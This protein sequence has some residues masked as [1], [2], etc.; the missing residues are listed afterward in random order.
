MH[1][2]QCFCERVPSHL[3]R[4]TSQVTARS[5][6]TLQPA[7]LAVDC[8]WILGQG[9]GVP[10]WGGLALA[11]PGPRCPHGP[12]GRPRPGS[13]AGT[14]LGGAARLPAPPLPVTGG[15]GAAGRLPPRG[16]GYPSRGVRWGG[17]L[18]WAQGE[19]L[20]GHGGVWGFPAA[21]SYTAVKRRIRHYYMGFRRLPNRRE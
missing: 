13:A 17:C 1:Y 16:V 8:H 10:T 20:T 6:L 3:E 18:W 11:H 7:R 4:K 12:A 14:P 19:A 21:M 9:T 2:T 15:R 5:H